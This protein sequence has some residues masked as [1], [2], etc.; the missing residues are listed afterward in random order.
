MDLK[1]DICPICHRVL[2]EYLRK[3]N[4]GNIAHVECSY[5]GNFKISSHVLRGCLCDRQQKHDPD[6]NMSIALRHLSSGS[7]DEIELTSENYDMIR[8]SVRIPAD[9]LEVLDI[10][11]SFCGRKASRFDVGIT[12]PKSDIPLLFV[13]DDNEM[14][15]V[16]VMAQELEYIG[17]YFTEKDSYVFSLLV[18][19][20]EKII[21]LRKVRSESK[22]VFVAMRFGDPDLDKVFEEA[23][24]PAI[25]LCGYHAYRIDRVQHNDKICDRIIA[26][27]KQ[28][29][30]VIADFTFHRG[31]VYFEAGFALGLGI[32]VIW[33]CREDD[34][35][36]LHFDTRQY[37]HVNWRSTEYLKQRLIDRIKAT[38]R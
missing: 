27:I 18:K 13:H 30:F 35:T 33:T 15:A 17:Q 20:W 24:V 7:D 14:Q 29:A 1:Q 16:L 21:Q 22:Q 12:I 8:G 23:I 10:L 37:N 9:P 5:C 19:G 3:S 36:D 4:Y 25:E 34:F 6:L 2:I 26:E 31:G 38:I 32:P 11:M 28:S